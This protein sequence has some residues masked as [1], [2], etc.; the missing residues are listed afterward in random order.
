MAAA[1]GMNLAQW[2]RALN[3]IQAVG[4]DCRTRV[5]SAGPTISRQST[6]PA[7]LVDCKPDP[8]DL[9]YRREQREILDQ[10]LY[11]LRDRERQILN[12]YYAHE[13][14]MKQIADQIGVDESR[15]SQLHAAALGRLKAG[16]GCLLHPQSSEVSESCARSV[17]AGAGA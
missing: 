10:A 8:F 3:E 2:H 11:R 1:A 14:T 13:L 9:T 16:V 17:A 6:D 4:F 5:V 12:L 7:L 15:I